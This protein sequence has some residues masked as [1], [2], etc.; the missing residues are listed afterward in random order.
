MLA[1]IREGIHLRAL[2]HGP[3]PFIMALDP[4]AEFHSEAVSDRHAGL[5][6]PARPPTGFCTSG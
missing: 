3:N 5:A 6:G 4:L 2:G 1:D